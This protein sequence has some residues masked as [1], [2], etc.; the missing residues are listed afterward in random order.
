MARVVHALAQFVLISLSVATPYLSDA[1]GLYAVSG[2]ALHALKPRRPGC[3]S[4]SPPSPHTR[5]LS[6]P[7]ILTPPERVYSC[8]QNRA[9]RPVYAYTRCCHAGL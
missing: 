9:L 4:A 1:P 8:S 3:S 5:R 6:P 7:S 2:V